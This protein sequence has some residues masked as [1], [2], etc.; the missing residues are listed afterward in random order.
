MSDTLKRAMDLSRARE[1]TKQAARAK[2]TY[3]IQISGKQVNDFIFGALL[4]RRLLDRGPDQQVVDQK[5]S[6][7]LS[8]LYEQEKTMPEFEEYRTLTAEFMSLMKQYEKEK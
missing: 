7:I 3:T 1:R 6:P 8:L 2:A 4:N 5:I